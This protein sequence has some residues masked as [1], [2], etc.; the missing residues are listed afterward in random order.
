MKC[1]K[2]GLPLDPGQLRE[3]PTAGDCWPV[4]KTCRSGEKPVFAYSRQTLLRTLYGAGRSIS[5]CHACGLQDKLELHWIRPLAAGGRPESNN[6]LA[7]CRAC[8]DKAHA[9]ARIIGRAAVVVRKTK[10][11]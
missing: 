9:G 10:T 11:E 3:T 5:A 4:C 6:L 7:L 2:C 8:H 1:S